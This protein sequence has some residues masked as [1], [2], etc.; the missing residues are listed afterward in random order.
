MPSNAIDPLVN[1]GGFC[2]YWFLFALCGVP[3]T[4]GYWTLMSTY[5]PRKNEK[6]ALPGKPLEEYIEIKDPQL[7]QHY[8]GEK[9]IPMQVLHDAYF[10]G[11]LFAR[12]VRHLFIRPKKA[13]SNTRRL[14]NRRVIP[15]S[16][17]REQPI[18][19]W[20]TAYMRRYNY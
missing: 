5:G 15:R 17:K 16:K 7:R 1:R 11:K 3:V 9:K 20:L 19:G 8:G 14:L 13:K 12:F 2:T 4:I 18:I 6:V 10:D